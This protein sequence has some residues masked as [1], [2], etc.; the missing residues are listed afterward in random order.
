VGSPNSTALKQRNGA[1]LSK[2][3]KSATPIPS[4]TKPKW[5][6]RAFFTQIIHHYQASDF[7]KNVLEYMVFEALMAVKL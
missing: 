5:V 2:A 3:W 1:T 7:L 4:E 6:S